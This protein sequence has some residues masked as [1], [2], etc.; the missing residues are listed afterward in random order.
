MVTAG[1]CG[2]LQG[3]TCV[4]EKIVCAKQIENVQAKLLKQ[5]ILF[6]PH[7]RF[8]CD[9]FPSYRWGALESSIYLMASS[10]TQRAQPRPTSGILVAITVMK[11]TLASRGRAA[12]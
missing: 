7:T 6:R 8:R 12:M 3:S 9:N 11:R 4:S 1:Q 2:E 10:P 5:N